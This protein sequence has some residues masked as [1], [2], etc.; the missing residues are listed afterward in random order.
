MSESLYTINTTLSTGNNTTKHGP[1]D[2]LNERHIYA[3][4]KTFNETEF[5]EFLVLIHTV[6]LCCTRK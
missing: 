2:C 4:H 6:T 1:H 5:L 3:T